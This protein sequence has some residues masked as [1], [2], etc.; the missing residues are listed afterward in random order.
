MESLYIEATK[1]SPEI[2]FDCDAH[3]L[4]ITGESYPGNIAEFYTPI[5]SWLENYLSAV[6]QQTVCVNIEL[7][8]FNSSSSKVFLDF[9]DLLNNAASQ[10]KKICL[11]WIYD[12][13]NSSMLEAGKEFQEDME[14]LEF[15]LIPKEA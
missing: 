3:L 14:S 9:F 15:H 1:S 10:R 8:Y 13:E 4:K 5:F 7:L 6:T 11:N 2:Y 12:K